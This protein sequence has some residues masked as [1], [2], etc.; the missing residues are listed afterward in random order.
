MEVLYDTRP[1]LL[2][3]FQ[4][5]FLPW[6]LN[7][8]PLYLCFETRNIHGD[9]RLSPRPRHT[10]RGLV[11]PYWVGGV[12]PKPLI[13]GDGLHEILK[14]AAKE[15]D[16]S[17]QIIILLSISFPISQP[18]FPFRSSFE[19]LKHRAPRFPNP[20]SMIW[21]L[22]QGISDDHI[23]A[24]FNRLDVDQSGRV[25]LA[26]WLI[27]VHSLRCHRSTLWL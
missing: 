27:E 14:I 16:I 18:Y 3:I 25:S 7:I 17:W 20:C 12:K 10:E 6:S 9:L 4:L 23:Y 11:G 22:A 1:Y 19:S 8:C 24:G 15:V 5:R 13:K 26:Q 21:R 2:G